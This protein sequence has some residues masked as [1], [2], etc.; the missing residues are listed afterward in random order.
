V[1]QTSSQPPP[2]SPISTATPAY[3]PSQVQTS[4]TA[5]GATSTTSPTITGS[6]S[7]DVMAVYAV[8]RSDQQNSSNLNAAVVSVALAY[9]VALT[10]FLS[11]SKSATEMGVAVLI[12]PFPVLSL[13]G[14]ISLQVMTGTLRR[15]YLIRLEARVANNMPTLNKAYPSFVAL[16]HALIMSSRN[17]PALILTALTYWS[18]LVTSALFTGYVLGPVA[19]TVNAPKPQRVVAICVYTFMIVINIT[20]VLLVQLRVQRNVASLNNLVEQRLD[21]MNSTWP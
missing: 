12:T 14:Y 3:G 5:P 15:A 7:I 1:S 4:P 19:N 10:S 13:N 9:V 11:N 2:Q 18:P 16:Y 21:K 20:A 6:A 17:A 8:E